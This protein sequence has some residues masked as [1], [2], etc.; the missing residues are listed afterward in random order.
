MTQKCIATR[1]KREID[2]HEIDRHEIDRRVSTSAISRETRKTETKV[3]ETN[4][5]IYITAYQRNSDRG[6]RL[7]LGQVV[8]VGQHRVEPR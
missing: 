4:E 6:G 7:Y 2:R 8:V 5:K 1:K 3:G